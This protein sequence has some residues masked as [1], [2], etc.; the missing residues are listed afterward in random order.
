[1]IKY[2]F[3]KHTADIKFQ[4]FGNSVEEVFENCA[5]AVIESMFE[6]I[7]I[8]KNIS[9]KIKITGKDFESLLYKF[10]EEIIYLLDGEN[11]AVSEIKNLR[12]KK[13]NLEAKFVGDESSE[14]NLSNKVKAM[15]YNDIF[16]KEKNGKWEAQ[17]VIDV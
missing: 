15:T 12:I 17:V 8:K 10:L 4:A 14:Y 16:I 7:K 6:K 13:F 2:K 5:L 1:M 11:F 3:L 9:K